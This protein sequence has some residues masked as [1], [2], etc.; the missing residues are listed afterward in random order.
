M[1]AVS[2]RHC[3]L[4]HTIPVPQQRSAV[5]RGHSHSY[6]SSPTS[7]TVVGRGTLLFT[8][9]QPLISGCRVSKC[10]RMT[11]WGKACKGEESPDAPAWEK[12]A[13]ARSH[14]M[15]RCTFYQAS[16]FRWTI[17]SVVYA[18]TKWCST[19]SYSIVSL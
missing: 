7:A 19:R 10:H 9:F 3:S 5:C 4:I 13:K 15:P 11:L 1:A 8:R 16:R 14:L 2:G 6:D 12:R 17:T 18:P